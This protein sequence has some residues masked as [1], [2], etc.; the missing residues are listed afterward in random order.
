VFAHLF[1]GVLLAGQ[2]LYWLTMLAALRQRFEPTETAR[3]LQI[4]RSARWPHVAVPYRLRLPLP[5]VMLLTLL[6]LILSGVAIVALRG[7]VPPT[8]VPW[9]LKWVLVLAV[10]VV[11]T[12]LASRPRPVVIRL[13]FVLVLATV[14]TSAVII[15]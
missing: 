12:M 8:S 10:T 6:T 3:L 14:V 7:G 4:V 2:A 13:G 5:W 9:G 15:R 1:L 11:L